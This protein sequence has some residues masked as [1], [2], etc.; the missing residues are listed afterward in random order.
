MP[1]MRLK[2][3]SSP[4]KTFCA[5]DIDG[6]RLFSWNTMLMPRP[7]ASAGDWKAVGSPSNS[8]VP[9]VGPVT[10][11]MILVSVDLPAPFSPTSAWISPASSVK[12][13]SLI[14]GTPRYSL[15]T[16][17]ISMSG[18]ISQ[19]SDPPSVTPTI[20][21][22]PRLAASSRPSTSIALVMPWRVPSARL[23]KLDSGW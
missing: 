4:R 17:R 12:S 10:P 1:R 9:L 23:W 2:N 15:V 22:Q 14:A 6:T 8:I 3:F 21:L 19:P 18:A 13:T 20:A 16:L 5:T 11:A 7:S